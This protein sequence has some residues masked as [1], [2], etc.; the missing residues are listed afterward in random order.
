MTSDI[1]QCIQCSIQWGFKTIYSTF[2]HL[3]LHFPIYTLFKLDLSNTNALCI[4][5]VTQSLRLVLVTLD[6]HRETH[7]QAARGS[8]SWVESLSRSRSATGWVSNQWPLWHHRAEL[9]TLSQSPFDLCCSHMRKKMGSCGGKTGSWWKEWEGLNC[10][11]T[12]RKVKQALVIHLQKQA[13]KRWIGMDKI[14]SW[15]CLPQR[16]LLIFVFLEGHWASA[17]CACR[18]RLP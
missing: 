9:G 8:G 12:N 7:S 16:E 10:R 17:V 5:K 18:A 3:H 15:M 2:L 1:I 6:L 11:N 14:I 4:S 13:K